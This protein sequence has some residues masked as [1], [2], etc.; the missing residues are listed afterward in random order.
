MKGS[1]LRPGPTLP[2]CTRLALGW[3]IHGLTLMGEVE[4]DA[5]LDPPPELELGD[6][7]EPAD[8]L[9]PP[10][11]DDGALVDTLSDVWV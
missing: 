10:R 2:T 7:L 6:A 4:A 8:G 3:S 9:E 5:E 11:D 1:P